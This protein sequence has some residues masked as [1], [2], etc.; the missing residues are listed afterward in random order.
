MAGEDK[1]AQ[2]VTA[3]PEALLK[4]KTNQDLIRFEETNFSRI[5]LRKNG[6]YWIGYDHTVFFLDR[7]YDISN[8]ERKIKYDETFRR[9]VCSVAFHVDN[10]LPIKTQLK[11]RL[12]LIT[13]ITGLVIF[14]L[15]AAVS[16]EQVNLWRDDHDQTSAVAAVLF[17][18]RLGNRVVVQLFIDLNSTLVSCLQSVRGGAVEQEL[19]HTTQTAFRH[20][21]D[22]EAYAATA[23]ERHHSARR[24]IS[25][26]QAAAL[27]SMSAYNAGF[28]DSSQ[29]IR[30]G[31]IQHEI[32]RVVSRKYLHPEKPAGSPSQE[33]EL[34]DTR[35]A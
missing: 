28:L 6:T 25:D 33:K 17:P 21:A 7:L 27:L 22:L 34:Q 32:I 16:P 12:T 18:D 31:Q 2:D 29:A 3:L 4:I 35:P 1:S 15:P 9:Q 14:T 8:K 13:G 20:Y 11:S 26:L 5:I 23:T 30:I 24:V 19:L 10:F